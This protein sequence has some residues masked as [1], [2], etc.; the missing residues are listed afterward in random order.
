MDGAAPRQ[1]MEP[2]TL[3]WLCGSLFFPFGHIYFLYPSIRGSSRMGDAEACV[4]RAHWAQGAA[5]NMLEIEL[6]AA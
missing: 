1:K 2:G 6:S 3:A 5:G 4:H